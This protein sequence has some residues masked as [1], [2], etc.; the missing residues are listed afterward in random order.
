VR[1]D[2]GAVGK[3]RPAVL[4]HDDA[5]AQQAPALL[6][7]KD[8]DLGRRAVGCVRGRA[9]RCVP[10][11]HWPAGRAKGRDVRAAAG[12]GLRAGLLGRQADHDID[13]LA[14]PG[15]V[16]GDSAAPAVQPDQAIE[17]GQA[18]AG[19]VFGGGLLPDRPP[20]RGVVVDLD[21]QVT[22]G[23]RHAD[24]DHPVTVTDGVGGQFADDEL[25]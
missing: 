15:A 3:Q 24:V 23:E 2:D 16:M 21:P 4:E 13:G 1:L 18:A 5:V 10:A 19:F 17:Q 20:V 12:S 11:R 6:R 9:A 25:G 7:V 22:A 14:A 8:G